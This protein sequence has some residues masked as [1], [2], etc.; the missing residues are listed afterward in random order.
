MSYFDI[1]NLITQDG[2]TNGFD[3]DKTGSDIATY[4]NTDGDDYN[5]K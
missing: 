3:G 1:V 5:G 4:D 2:P